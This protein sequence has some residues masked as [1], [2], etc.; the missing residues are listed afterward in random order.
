MPGSEL[1]HRFVVGRRLVFKIYK[2]DVQLSRQTSNVRVTSATRRGA[3]AQI[4]VVGLLIVTGL[5]AGFVLFSN[6][7]NQSDNTT[8]ETDS[9]DT[10]SPSVELFPVTV[11][12]PD[13]PVSCLSCHNPHAPITRGDS[14]GNSR[15]FLPRKSIRTRAIFQS[16]ASARNDGKMSLLPASHTQ[17]PRASVP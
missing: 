1:F 4:P 9:R 17:W 3:A 5:I 15:K 8:A 12:K 11:R 16:R 6:R 14:N 7:T 10:E 2:N 13:G